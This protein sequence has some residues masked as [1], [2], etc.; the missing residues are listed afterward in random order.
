M[1]KTLIPKNTYLLIHISGLIPQGMFQYQFRIH[2]NHYFTLNI[3][4]YTLKPLIYCPVYIE[5]ICLDRSLD[6]INQDYEEAPFTF[7]IKQTASLLRSLFNYYFKV[8]TS[9]ST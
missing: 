4:V 3:Y 5:Q 9:Q 6:D 2:L 8:Q 7:S 1:W